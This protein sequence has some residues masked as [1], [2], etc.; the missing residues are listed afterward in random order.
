[1]DYQI[2]T[3]GCDIKCDY[4]HN[5]YLVPNAYANGGELETDSIL[6][7]AEICSKSGLIYEYYIEDKPTH[8]HSFDNVLRNVL[9]YPSSFTIPDK[10]RYQYSDQEID[11]IQK[12]KCD[13]LDRINKSK[14]I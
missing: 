13:I 3:D 14:A 1:M 11:L 6:D 10:F 4:Y 8:S 7:V 9:K 2:V 5:M 12:F